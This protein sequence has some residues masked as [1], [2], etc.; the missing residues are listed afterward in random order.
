MP[1]M[2]ALHQCRGAELLRIPGGELGQSE[3]L[4][5]NTHNTYHTRV[6]EFPARYLYC[7]NSY[8]AKLSTLILNNLKVQ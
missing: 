1:G 3:G 2:G 6:K 5:T 4:F 7:Y 8:F